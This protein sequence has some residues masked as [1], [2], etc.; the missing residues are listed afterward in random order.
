MT[1]ENELIKKNYYKRLMED[2]EANHPIQVLADVFLTEKENELLDLTDI[3]FSQGEV[4]YHNRDFEAAIFKWENVHNELEPWAK[5]NMADAY[6]ELGLRSTAEEIYLSIHSENLIL[7][8]EVALQLFSIYI[9]QEQLDESAKVIKNTVFL[10]PDYPNVTNIARSFFEEYRDWGSAIELAVNEAIRT[11]SLEWFDILKTYVEK[12]LTTAIEPVYF[13]KALT[14]LSN[15][16]QSRLEQLVASFWNSYRNQEFYFSWMIEFNNLFLNIEVDRSKSWNEMSTLYEE[17][18]FELI[19]GNFFINELADVVPN[20]LTNWLK[21]TTS[22]QALM[23]A[24]AVLSWNEIFPSSISSVV[25]NEAETLIQNSSGFPKGREYSLKLFEAIMNWAKGHDVEVGNRVKWIVDEL[26]NLQV[27]HLLVA[28][29]A[30]NGKTSF[31]NS[32][33]GETILEA[34]TSTLV[35]FR[36]GEEV[37][38]KEITDSD[39]NCDLTLS[40]FHTIT[41]WRSQTHVVDFTLPCEFLNEHALSI[42]DTPS[43]KGAKDERNDWSSYLHGADSLLYVLNAHNPFS[44]EE[45][46]ILL[47][48]QERAPGLPIHFLVNKIDVINNEMEVNKILDET[49]S[50]INNYFPNATVIAYS[51]HFGKEYRSGLENFIQL[52]FSNRHIKE[53]RNE[54]LLYY[55]RQTIKLLLEKRVEIENNLAEAVTW[56]EEAVTK[57]S[58]AVN[59]LND[60]EK[61]K[62]EVIKSSYRMIKDELKNDLTEMIPKLLR[63]CTDFINEDSDFRNIQAD[64]NKEMNNRIDNYIHHTLV[65]KFSSSIQEWLEMSNVEF[66]QSQSYLKEMSDGFNALYGEERFKLDCDFRVLDDWCRD[67]DRMTNGMR[68]ENVNVLL[69]LT[70]SQFL[71]KSSGKLFGALPTNK[72][73]LGKMY[74]KFIENEDYVYVAESLTNQMLLPLELFEKGLERD[75]TMFFRN[76]Y[77]V[78]NEAIEEAR[79]NIQVHND[80][81]SDVKSNPEIFFDPLTLFEVRLRHY[82]LMM[83]VKKKPQLIH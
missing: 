71:L 46:D 54:K 79:V 18:Y 31:I 69:R 77:S 47:T 49:R 32:I 57:L 36:G 40:D 44:D 56:N 35:K 74:K 20:L 9:E 58:G 17:T 65:P 34:S 3:R 51:A 42:I 26:L 23:A 19:S 59:Q 52:I 61:E 55:V 1:L 48:I 70:P 38:I 24:A 4:Y 8:T 68:M 66:I 2:N 60:L 12:G 21:V 33:L 28:G 10:N 63:D 43:Y 75:I 11:E 53:E 73:M 14:T 25:A 76:P 27:N 67:A 45:R 62:I 5:K 37:K 22:S 16:D 72:T 81:L 39:I 50:R 29:T 7:N 80:A 30:G 6:Y 82:E 64:L 78:L 13:S 41:A 83:G 15:L